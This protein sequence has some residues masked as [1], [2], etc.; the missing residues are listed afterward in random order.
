MKLAKRYTGRHEIIACTDADC[1][2]PVNWLQDINRVFAQEQVRLAFGPV[3]FDP[4]PRPLMAL[5]F[6]ALIGSTMGMLARDQH[7]MGNGANMA[8]RK[9][10]YLYA[11]ERMDGSSSPTGDDVFFLHAMARGKARIETLPPSALVRTD[12]P[13]SL[14]DF[15]QQ[16]I[17]WASKGRHY[18]SLSTVLLAML[19]FSINALLLITVLGALF[20]LL[21]WKPFFILFLGKSVV[22]VV[23]L[24]R[25]AK[26]FDQPM[27]DGHVLQ[28]QLLNMFY[29]P[30]IAVLSTFRSYT[31]KGRKY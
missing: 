12:S 8:F 16:R 22:D 10:A 9:Q 18:R 20:L 15:V 21:P 28:Q 2:L 17:R 6:L 27:N 5:E 13:A 7:V 14:S 25:F 31:W 30:T 29:I 24:K 23:L 3:A 19:I 11:L 26:T 4:I 1:E